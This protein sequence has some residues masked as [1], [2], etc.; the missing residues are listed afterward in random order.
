M[1]SLRTLGSG[2]CVVLAAC[3]SSKRSHP[4][5]PA[6]PSPALRV[7][8]SADTTHTVPDVP[9]RATTSP[10]AVPSP[11]TTLPVPPIA[12]ATPPPAPVPGELRPAVTA[13]PLPAAGVRPA[14]PGSPST[15][16]ASPV[17]S[18]APSS[19]PAVARVGPPPAPPAPPAVPS[20]ARS[21][22]STAPANPTP[23]WPTT[24]KE[25]L[26]ELNRRAHSGAE[27]EFAP[28]A[29][30]IDEI[31]AA[32]PTAGA[33]ITITRM[34]DVEAREKASVGRGTGWCTLTYFVEPGAD[35]N[36]MRTSYLD[37][38]RVHEYTGKPGASLLRREGEFT[39]G[40]TDAIR[41]VLA[42]EFGARWTFRAKSLDRGTARLVVTAMEPAEDTFR[43]LRTRGVIVVFPARD[44]L[45]VAEANA[46]L[47]DFEV[48]PLLK[49]SAE[50]IAR[51][52]MLA[53]VAGIRAHWREYLK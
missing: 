11:T 38:D 20:I 34:R 26:A 7:S 22:P 32:V 42:F 18:I 21:A 52:E 46:S 10:V 47:V 41:R 31:A 37:I 33:E 5:E 25:F 44:G 40:R 19:P 30:L 43:M 8:S 1:P 36:A 48:P 23:P 3:T 16:A 45:F 17:P 15:G 9:A 28:V 53:R 4:G 12:T 24:L 39:I 6:P 50:G 29:D 14:A 51:K 27:P 35:A 49:G 2:L 13:A